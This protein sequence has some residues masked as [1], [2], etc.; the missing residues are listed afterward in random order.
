MR[1]ELMLSIYN[2]KYLYGSQFPSFS[3]RLFDFITFRTVIRQAI[4]AKMWKRRSVQFLKV[5]EQKER[6]S[7]RSTISFGSRCQW[8]NFFSLGFIFYKVHSLS[9]VIVTGWWSNI[10]HVSF[11]GVHQVQHF[12]T[13]LWVFV[14]TIITVFLLLKIPDRF[15]IQI[16]QN[17]HVWSFKFVY[18]MNFAFLYEFI[19]RFYLPTE[20]CC[21]L[22]E[23]F[24]KA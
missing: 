4:I 22:M 21:I 9:I 8:H 20:K 6:S 23:I 14:N 10:G 5:R 11:W 13:L 19:T 2:E 3:P 24:L 15:G 7:R 1:V 12:W 18:P 17:S 16:A